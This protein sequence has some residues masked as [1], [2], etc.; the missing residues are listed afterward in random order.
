MDPIVRQFPI[1]TIC[2][3]NVLLLFPITSKTEHSDSALWVSCQHP[4]A[5]AASFLRRKVAKLNIKKTSIHAS[6]TLHLSGEMNG[7][8]KH[9]WD[10][11]R[12]L[13]RGGPGLCHIA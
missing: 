7:S 1:K 13:R 4:S 2:F 5:L 11:L 10:L 9:T 12:L 8:V 3:E 6:A